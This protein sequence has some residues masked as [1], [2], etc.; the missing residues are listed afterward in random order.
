MPISWLVVSLGAIFLSFWCLLL[1][2]PLCLQS[3]TILL[4]LIRYTSGHGELSVANLIRNAKRFF[5]SLSK[6]SALLGLSPKQTLSLYASSYAQ[7]L[8]Y[9]RLAI[10]SLC[11]LV[12]STLSEED[13][14]STGH[15]YNSNNYWELDVGGE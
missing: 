8:L 10:Q 13:N 11:S 6:L 15:Y 7:A 14:G 12:Y 4:C 9:P 3:R 5:I 1:L 2:S